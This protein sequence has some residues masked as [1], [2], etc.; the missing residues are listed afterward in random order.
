MLRNNADV[1]DPSPRVTSSTP[2]RREIR[3]FRLRVAVDGRV[4]G[5]ILWVRDESFFTATVSSISSSPSSPRSC[6]SRR[7]ISSRPASIALRT[8]SLAPW[9]LDLASSSACSVESR[10]VV[11]STILR[12]RRSAQIVPPTPTTTPLV[13]HMGRFNFYVRSWPCRHS[14]VRAAAAGRSLH[15]LLALTL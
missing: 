5:A 11:S 8:R 2:K 15:L 13:N 6:S 10:A 12:T 14:S 9:I 4:E 3:G 1:C 7:S